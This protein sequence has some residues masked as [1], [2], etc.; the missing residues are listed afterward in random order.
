[1]TQHPFRVP[2]L[3]AI[4]FTLALGLAC[5][6]PAPADRSADDL[7]AEARRFDAAG[8]HSDAVAVY[9]QLLDRQPDSFDGHYWI[10]RALDLDGRYEEAR[11][12]FSRA[13][14]LSSDSNRDQ[15]LRMMGIAWVFEANTSEASRYFT[16]V[17]DRRMAAGNPAAAAEV[18]NE[19]ARVY[20]ESGDLDRADEW[21]RTG[22]DTAL[23]ETGM[24]PTQAG[25]AELRWAHAQARIAARRGR[26]VDARRH[27]AEV[28]R[29]IDRTGDTDQ[30]VQYAY[31]QGYVAFHLGESAAAIEALQRADQD[32]PF[33]Q[34]LLAQSGERTGDD[35]LASASFAAVLASTSHAINAAFARPVARR[36]LEGR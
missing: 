35:A 25:L 29:L 13:I 12:H 34:L 27:V 26:S 3:A 31:L 14:D 16:E 4:A 15:S 18:A 19:L 8:A 2:T 1:M 21:Y 11:T 33:I 20:L 22:Y 17:F 6:G 5:G 23:G 32:D 30:E 10:A 9:R 24:S 7:F 36:Y 28:R